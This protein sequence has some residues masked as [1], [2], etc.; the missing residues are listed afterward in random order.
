[1]KYKVLF[2]GII[3]GQKQNLEAT[4]DSPHKPE[5]T[6]KVVIR[7]AMAALSEVVTVDKPIFSIEYHIEAILPLV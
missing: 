3:N 7:A 6:D 1:M 5:L 4:F 2:Y